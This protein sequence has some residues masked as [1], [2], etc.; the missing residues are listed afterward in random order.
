MSK[1][2]KLYT[3]AGIFAAIVLVICLTLSLL[4]ME[5]KMIKSNQTIADY[6]IADCKT[7]GII[8]NTAFNDLLSNITC[9]RTSIFFEKKYPRSNYDYEVVLHIK[10]AKGVYEPWHIM[11]SK[12]CPCYCYQ[13]A[14][15]YREFIITTPNFPEL[16]DEVL[17]MFK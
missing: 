17:N 9:K 10:N 16:F 13:S 1:K 3:V 2:N 14:G 8:Q 15:P 5:R 7:G 11:V 4:F 12:T 6:F